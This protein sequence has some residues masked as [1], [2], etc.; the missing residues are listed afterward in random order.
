M[1]DYTSI[2]LNWNF[3]Y[4]FDAVTEIRKK[5]NKKD[6]LDKGFDLLSYAKASP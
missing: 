3:D 2:C 1:T 5:G 6:F 4:N